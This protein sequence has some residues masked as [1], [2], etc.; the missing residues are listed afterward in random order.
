MWISKSTR[1]RSYFGVQSDRPGG[2]QLPDYYV[3]FETKHIFCFFDHTLTRPHSHTLMCVYVGV[4]VD[5]DVDVS[6]VSKAQ[7]CVCV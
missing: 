7:S 5:V 6:V 4:D 1:R 3:S 2:D